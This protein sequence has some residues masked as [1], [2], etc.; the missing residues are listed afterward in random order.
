MIVALRA[1]FFVLSAGEFIF[2]KEPVAL[3]TQR[4]G[5]DIRSARASRENH[6]GEAKPLQSALLDA[7][8]GRKSMQALHIQRTPLRRDEGQDE[9]CSCLVPMHKASKDTCAKMKTE[10]RRNSVINTIA[11]HGMRDV[12]QLQSMKNA[13]LEIE[14]LMKRTQIAA[15]AALGDDES[16]VDL[17]LCISSIDGRRKDDCARMKSEDKRNTA[18]S[19]LTARGQNVQQLQSMDDSELETF[20]ARLEKQKRRDNLWSPINSPINRK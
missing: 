2:N 3:Q 8:H 18:I 1:S 19:I 11:A 17:C 5:P 10:E 14:C 6:E 20:C 4:T 9:L 15:T 16:H 13:E 7:G 12:S